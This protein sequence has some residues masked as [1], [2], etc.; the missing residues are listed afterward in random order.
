M[1]KYVIISSNSDMFHCSKYLFVVVEYVDDVHVFV[2][3]KFEH[4]ES[5]MYIVFEHDWYAMFNFFHCIQVWLFTVSV[6]RSLP[7]FLTLSFIF[8]HNLRVYHSDWKL[9]Y[10][11]HGNRVTKLF[12]ICQLWLC[13]YQVIWRSLSDVVQTHS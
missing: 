3:Y 4:N 1:F 5:H 13:H 9:V 12:D 8:L 10:N 6:S 11:G 7:S 2:W